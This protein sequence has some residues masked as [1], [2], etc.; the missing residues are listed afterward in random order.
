MNI[1]AFNA[2]KIAV[3]RDMFTAINDQTFFSGTV[4]ILANVAPNMP[5]PTI[6]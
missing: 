5:A 3:T 6:R 4:T 1:D 2:F